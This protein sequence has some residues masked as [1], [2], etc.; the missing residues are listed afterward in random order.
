M[1]S[2]STPDHIAAFK[3]FRPIGTFQA[4]NGLS[5]LRLRI[6]QWLFLGIVRLR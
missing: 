3:C 6:L 5:E 2:D 1:E 4:L